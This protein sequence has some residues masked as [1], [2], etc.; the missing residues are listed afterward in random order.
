MPFFHCTAS[1]SPAPTAIECIRATV[2]AH[3][4]ELKSMRDDIAW[5]PATPQG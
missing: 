5:L 3:D 1:S 4:T 2:K